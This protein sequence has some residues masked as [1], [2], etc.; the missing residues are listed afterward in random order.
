MSIADVLR[1]SLLVQQY[2]CA[3]LPLARYLLRAVIQLRLKRT[4]SKSHPVPKLDWSSL[5]TPPSQQLFQIA[6]SNRFATL[7]IGSRARMCKIVVPRHPQPDTT[8][9]LE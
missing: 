7:A 4:T 6:L 1:V 8:V 5:M 3:G 9:D 2:S